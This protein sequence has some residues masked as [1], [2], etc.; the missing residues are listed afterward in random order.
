MIQILKIIVII[1]NLGIQK[2]VLIIKILG[3]I[4]LVPKVLIRNKE[5]H[6]LSKN[7]GVGLV[8]LRRQYDHFNANFML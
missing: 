3:K 6:R 5:F 4:L 1:W 8:Y 7:R 2:T